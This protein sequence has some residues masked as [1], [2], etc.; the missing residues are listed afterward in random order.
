MTIIEECTSTNALID[1]AAAHGE[2][3]LARVQT[4]GR[5]Q[6]GNTWEAEPYKNISMSIMLRP[7]CLPASR[8][9]ELSEAVALGVADLLDSLE[10]SEV[11]VKWPNDV[12]VGDGKICGILI[13][14]SLS[15]TFIGRSIAGIGLNV[16]QTEFLSS[17]PNPLSLKQLTGL[18]Y[19][20][21]ELAERLVGC[22][23]ARLER[24][25]DENHAEYRSRLWRGEGEWPWQ[26]AE[27][28][29][30]VAHIEDVLPTGHLVLSGCGK[31]FAF[32]EVKPL[33]FAN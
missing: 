17:A 5:G 19:D 20:V 16:N 23:L 13:E 14:N 6:R 25:A 22:V 26:T 10:I 1:R 30:F 4:S 9:F 18:D 32:K 3:L 8:Q 11:K 21:C 29:S 31:P 24:R 28:E 15:G 33:G 27:G 12:Y 7:Q 2:A